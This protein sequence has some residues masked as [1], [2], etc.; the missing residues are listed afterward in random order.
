[1]KKILFLFSI[2]FISCSSSPTG[3]GSPQIKSINL[4]ANSTSDVESLQEGNSL[5]FGLFP[6]DYED[7]VGWTTVLDIEVDTSGNLNYVECFIN[8]VSVGKDYSEPFLWNV[9]VFQEYIPAG[10]RVVSVE[11]SKEDG[12]IIS[13][14]TNIEIKKYYFHRAEVLDDNSSPSDR[15]KISFTRRVGEHVVYGPPYEFYHETESLEQGEDSDEFFLQEGVYDIRVEKNFTFF[16]SY[17][18][19]VGPPNEDFGLQYLNL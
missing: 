9:D 5:V 3:S 7:S 15:Y 6:T 10:N 17:E 16:R 1:M 11:L 18:Y 13:S 4:S 12:E 8:N 2:I 19:T 14:S